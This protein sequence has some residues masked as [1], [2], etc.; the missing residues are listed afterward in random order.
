MTVLEAGE[1]ACGE[2]ERTTAHLTAVSDSR[3]YELKRFFGVEGMRLAGES[4]SAAIDYIEKIV[5]DEG[6]NC[7][8]E[9]VDGYLYAPKGESL[10]NELA[11]TREI[12]AL[13]V[14]RVDAPPVQLW[15]G[16]PCL[17]FNH[18]D[19]STP[20]STSIC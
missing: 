12:K 10:D 9:R 7:D 20:S 17:R 6:I 3:F 15:E 8:F 1:I 11:C 13:S 5:Q 19:R 4:H 2:T 18:Q 14:E 16:G